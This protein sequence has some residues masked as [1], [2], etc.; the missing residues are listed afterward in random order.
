MPISWEDIRGRLAKP[1][2]KKANEAKVVLKRVTGPTSYATGGFDVTIGDLSQ[3]VS[4]IVVAGSGY[5]AEVDFANSNA[6]KLR[7]KAY[8]AAGTEVTAGTN[9]STV[10]FT[11]MAFG[12]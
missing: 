4:A 9:L 2:Q 7:I 1:T 6:N 5:T 12:H 10:Y 3:I 8:S 11:I